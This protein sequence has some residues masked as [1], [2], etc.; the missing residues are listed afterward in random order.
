MNFDL[1]PFVK[2]GNAR[3]RLDSITAFRGDQSIQS[4][5]HDEHQAQWYIIHI[6]CSDQDYT[7]KYDTQEQRDSVLAAL[8][9][10]T[11]TPKPPQL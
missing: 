8:D 5:A 1:T 2:L 9:Q 10:F 3:L 4:K 7:I 6:K 11:F